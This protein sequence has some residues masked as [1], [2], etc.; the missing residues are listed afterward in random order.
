[1]IRHHIKSVLIVAALSGAL[2][3][4]IY[5]NPYTGTISLSELVLQLS[6]SRGE[7][8]LGVSL[9]ELLGFAMR[10]V[11]SYIASAFIGTEL[12]RH[13]CTASV[14]V[15]S[16]HPNRLS[17][18]AKEVGFIFSSAVVFYIIQLATTIVTTIF[19]YQID[20]D[21]AG[22]G[23]L[24][25]H[26]AI[27]TLWLFTM[28]MLINLLSV[29]FGSDSAFLSVIIGQS[30]LITLLTFASDEV[31]PLIRTI[32]PIAHLVLQWHGCTNKLYDGILATAYPYLN[33]DST[34]LLM[35]L[36]GIGIVT[37][38]GLILN[39]HDLL[40]SNMETGR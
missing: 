37:A 35:L 4:V 18:Y 36:L 27:Y 12:Y 7:F 28:S 11:P 14:Y 32:N 31:S 38:C 30:A 19:R 34:L 6:G 15:F 39:K 23:L 8:A 10:M 40:I 24:L 13:Y 17:W 33:L 1:M 5:V 26:L 25:Y 3:A 20:F 21:W 9:H 16:R 22:C 2:Q 29:F